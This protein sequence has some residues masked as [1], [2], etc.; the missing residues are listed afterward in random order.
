[1]PTFMDAD[2]IRAATF[3][4]TVEVHETLGS[5]NDRAAA[6][7]RDLTVELPALVVARQQTAGRGRGTNIWQ[8]SDGALTFSLLIDPASFGISTAKWPQVSLATAVAVCDGLA[9]GLAA[10]KQIA[11]GGDAPARSLNAARLAIKW[12]ND[13]MLDGA[14]TCGILIESPGGV[15]PA[16]D[17]LIMGVGIN[18]NNSCREMARES[19]PNRIAICDV[20]HKHDLQEVLVAVIGAIELRLKQVGN[21]DPQLVQSWQEKC[22]LTEQAV[23]VHSGSKWVDGICLGIDGDGALLVENVFGVHRL[24]SGSVRVK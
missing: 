8:S 12:P 2:E 6:L 20:S 1:M 13:V 22:W 15:A 24:S 5:T 21:D 17:R 16:K 10:E 11:G 3:V 23:E 4:R 9:A 14:K 7:A 19:G 18:V